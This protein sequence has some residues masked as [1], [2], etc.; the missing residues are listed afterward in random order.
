MSREKLY[1]DASQI[2]RNSVETSKS[3]SPL[4]MVNSNK[5]SNTPKLKETKKN[6]GEK[7][8]KQLLES[9]ENEIKLECS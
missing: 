6:E 2:N 7:T 3:R 5:L 9:K 4:R 8:F 1:R